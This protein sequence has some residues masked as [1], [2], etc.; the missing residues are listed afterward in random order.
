MTCPN[1]LT[2][3]GICAGK[4]M[5][6]RVRNQFIFPLIARG[7]EIT[8]VPAAQLEASNISVGK[9]NFVTVFKN[10]CTSPAAPSER[11]GEV[12]RPNDRFPGNE[13][14]REKKKQEKNSKCFGNLLNFGHSARKTF[15]LMGSLKTRGK[16]RLMGF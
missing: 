6:M 14:E 10:V 4:V 3:K 7:L 15:L 12:G 8:R 13:R 9:R 16:T 5:K 11:G 1:R 2:R